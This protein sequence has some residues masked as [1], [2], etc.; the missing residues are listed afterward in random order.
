MD[1]KRSEGARVARGP[2]WPLA[3]PFLPH[4][5]RIFER[6]PIQA[7]NLEDGL[8]IYAAGEHG[9]RGFD[10]CF[11]PSF[12]T[13]RSRLSGGRRD[14]VRRSLKESFADNHT[15]NRKEIA[16]A[17]ADRFFADGAVALIK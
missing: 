5:G 9:T 7:G 11:G 4:P 17:F 15:Q 10:L 14:K 16:P 2:R 8:D 13:H 3:S 6:L 12:G 1:A